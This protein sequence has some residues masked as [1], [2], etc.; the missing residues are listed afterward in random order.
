MAPNGHCWTEYEVSWIKGLT[1][2][3]PAMPRHST[4]KLD[5][6]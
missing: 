4:F 2:G 5:E 1:N 6:Y 3:I